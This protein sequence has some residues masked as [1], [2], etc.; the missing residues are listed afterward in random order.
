MTALEGCYDASF[1]FNLDN[2]QTD[3]TYISYQIGGTAINGVDYKKIDNAIIIPAGQTSAT[4]IIDAASLCEH[5]HSDR[6]I[7]IQCP[8]FG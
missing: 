3:D 7:D 8:R 1:T 5:Y 2:P 4:I 6:A